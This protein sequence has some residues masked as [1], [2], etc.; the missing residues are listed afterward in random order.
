MPVSEN[1]TLSACLPPDP[2]VREFIQEQIRA[3]NNAHS[4]AHRESRKSG[5][6]PLDFVLRDAAGRLCG[7]LLADTYWGWVEI[8]DLWIEE[9]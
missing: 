5:L 2:R 1:L 7:G 9:T 4:P 8:L 6:R 3:F